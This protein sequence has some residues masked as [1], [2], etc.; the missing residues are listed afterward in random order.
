[1]ETMLDPSRTPDALLMSIQNMTFYLDYVM[2]NV[3]KILLIWKCI[4]YHMYMEV[5]TGPYLFHL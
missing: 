1:M 4:R 3:D 5:Y 2:Q